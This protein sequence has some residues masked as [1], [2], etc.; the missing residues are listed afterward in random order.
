MA[1]QQ[2]AAAAAPSSPVVALLSA[3]W[4]LPLFWTLGM[5]G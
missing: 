2:A 3:L 4:S 5:G 1:V